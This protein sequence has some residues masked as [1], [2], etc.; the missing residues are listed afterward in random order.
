MPWDEGRTYVIRDLT[1]SL[2][3]EKLLA[4]QG[5]ARGGRERSPYVGEMADKMCREAVSL[6][7]PVFGYGYFSVSG[8][9]R[10]TIGL[11]G[12]GCFR[13]SFLA[14]KL[15]PASGLVVMAST[16]GCQVEDKAAEYYE[17]GKWLDSYLLDL[18]GSALAEA[19]LYAGFYRVEEQVSDLGLE[20]TTPFQPGHSYWG[21]LTAQS[22]I[23]ELLDCAAVGI[24]LTPSMVM[25]P[26]KS[27]TAVSGV[28]RGFA[29]A[30]FH[31]SYCERRKTC[32][33]SRV[34]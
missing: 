20:I 11:G 13:S 19:V 7:R 16:I 18:A 1:I 10:D 27:I 3:G 22:L 24:T 6:A 15:S 33:L 5:T 21:D 32:M 30:E 14:R 9:S 26:K 12:S 25:I 23:F 29:A 8:I 34:K 28:G 17:A 31:C 4:M 2:S